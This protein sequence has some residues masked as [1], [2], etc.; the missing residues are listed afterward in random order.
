MQTAQTIDALLYQAEEQLFIRGTCY[1]SRVSENVKE[2]AVTLR[3]LTCIN[4]TWFKMKYLAGER[5]TKKGD[6]RQQVFDPYSLEVETINKRTAEKI[7]GEM[8]ESSPTDIT[9]YFQDYITGIT[10]PYKDILIVVHMSILE[11]LFCANNFITDLAQG[12]NLF[13]RL[14][15]F[16]L[17]CS[18]GFQSSI[19]PQHITS[20]S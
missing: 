10:L 12:Y 17:K 20:N 19:V 5:C 15:S 11:G 8:M 7:M 13:Y 1:I 14:Q 9:F 6:N 2:E 3:I 4:G 16:R 18:R